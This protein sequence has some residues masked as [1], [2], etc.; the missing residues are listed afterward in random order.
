MKN[1]FKNQ[2]GGLKHPYRT[3]F[4]LGLFTLAAIFLLG[5][6]WVLMVQNPEIPDNVPPELILERGQ[7]RDRNGR[8]LALQTRLANI[9]LWRPQIQDL[10]ILSRELDPILGIPGEE[11]K[12]RIRSSRSDFLYLKKQVDEST[13]KIIDNKIQEGRLRGVKIEPVVRRIYP[14]RNLASQIIGFMGNDGEGLGGIEYAFNRELSPAQGNSSGSTVYLTIDSNVQFI[15]ERIASAVLEENQAEAVMLMAMD[16]RTGDVLGSASLPG[17]DPNDI[18]LTSNEERMD[19]PALWAYEPG[20]V[21]KI[22]SMASLLDSGAIGEESIFICNGSYEK[23]TGRG[24]IIHINCLGSHGRVRAREIIIYSCNAGA[25]YAADRTV[26]TRFYG[27]LRDFGFGMRTG[28]GNPGETAGF[29]RSAD[30]WSDRSKP[31][32]AMGQEIAVSAL[33]MIQA[34]GAIANDGILVPVRVVSHTVSPDGKEIPFENG[35]PRRVLK[36]ESARALRSYMV[37]VT[38]GIGTGWRANVEDLSLAVKTGTAQIIDPAT[39]AYS[40]TDFIASCL[41]MLPAESPSLILY[42]VI[43]KPRGDY[44]GG[45]IAAPPIREAAEALTDYLGIPRG[46]NPQIEHSPQVSISEEQIADIGETIP[47]FSGFSKRSLLPLILRDDIHVEIQGDGWVRRQSP[48]PDSAV[49]PG[50]T[51]QLFLE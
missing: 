35:Q 5:R 40:D 25:G 20:S 44:L 33:Q 47:D 22:F 21:F 24:E 28:A 9:S 42:L 45:R 41:A 10:E 30:R 15:L 6:Y 27:Q 32:I 2:G 43:M 17:F 51:I 26:N 3:I 1:P 48:P 34:A 13:I 7:I 39:N 50:M 11:L 18:R 49:E 38:S 4:F 36:P 37:D 16:P 46:R 31:T 23:T 8:I 12:E 19:R 14:E 29:L